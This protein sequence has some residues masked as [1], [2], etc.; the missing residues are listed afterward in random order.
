MGL[1]AILALLNVTLPLLIN[2]AETLF[3]KPGSGA[4]KKAAA[5]GTAQR[6]LAANGAS[7]TDAP[8][9]LIGGLIEETLTAMKAART[10]GVISALPP[11]AQAAASGL[12]PLRT[13]VTFEGSGSTPR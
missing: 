2:V 12:A 4:A 13:G 8:V 3:T 7:A 9:E 11:A 10:L 5:M 1:A 6:V